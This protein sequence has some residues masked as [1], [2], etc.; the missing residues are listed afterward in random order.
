MLRK[1]EAQSPPTNSSDL[2]K[3]ALIMARAFGLLDFLFSTY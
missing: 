1:Q 2:I 3:G